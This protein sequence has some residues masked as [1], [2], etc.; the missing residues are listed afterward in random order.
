MSEKIESVEALIARV[1]AAHP[2]TSRTALAVYFEAV[3]QELAPLAR[4]LE[5]RVAELENGLAES[6]AERARMGNLLNKT[7][8]ALLGRQMGD[9]S[10]YDWSDAPTRAE[11]AIA[12]LGAATHSFYI[13]HERADMLAEMF[14]GVIDVVT[15]DFESNGEF[16]A[17]VRAVL[18]KDPSLYVSEIR[19][20]RDSL[21]AELEIER[22]R[23]AACGVVAMA[24]T[25]ES[26]A[27]A[28]DMREEYRSAS[29][30]DVARRV[31]EC[32]ALRTERDSLRLACG[33][34]YQMAG[35]L[36][37]PTNALDNLSAASTG[38]PL[39]HE[40]FLPVEAPQIDREKVRDAIAEA[41]GCTIYCCT[42]VWN[43]WGVGTMS[44][45]DFV[46]ASED[47]GILDELTAAAIS[48]IEARP[49]SGSAS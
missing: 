2:N 30:D 12:G 9:T 3:H 25:P 8:K 24:D 43:A 28:R 14:K 11:A 41:L 17:R 38:A 34:A 31:D 23:L 4:S 15:T 1:E 13:E 27:K 22:I 29:C 16:V 33:E 21:K 32:I 19:K 5:R 18:G 48:A 35:V 7:V 46:L 37:A 40:T 26:A 10:P 42:R 36:G 47:D 20:E 49:E 44:Q 45:D 6:A 39:P